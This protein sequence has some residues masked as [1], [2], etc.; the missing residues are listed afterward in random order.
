MQKAKSKYNNQKCYCDGL[1]FDSK[2]EMNYYAVL[3]LQKKAG[4]IKDIQCQVPFELLPGY[5]TKAGE[6][7]RKITYLADFVVAYADGTTEVIDVKGRQT[8]VYKL[9]KKMLLYKYPD[10]N[11]KEVKVK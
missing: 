1:K 5:T 10:I 4:L 2:A 11:F 3:T 6:R 7:V 9:K 8:D